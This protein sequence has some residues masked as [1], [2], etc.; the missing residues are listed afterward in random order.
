MRNQSYRAYRTGSGKSTKGMYEFLDNEEKKE[1]PPKPPS[2]KGPEKRGPDGT[3]ERALVKKFKN[4]GCVMGN[5]GVRN[6]K[7]V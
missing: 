2:K 4:G 7:M 3:L 5:R 1:G 6:T